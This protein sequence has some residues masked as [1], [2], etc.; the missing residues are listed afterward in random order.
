MYQALT[1]MMDAIVDLADFCSKLKKFET[2][3]VGEKNMTFT[4]EYYRLQ[5]RSD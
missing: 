1:L 5:K 4:K 2:I 3:A